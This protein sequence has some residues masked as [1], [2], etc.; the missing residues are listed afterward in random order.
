MLRDLDGQGEVLRVLVWLCDSGSTVS[1]E[2]QCGVCCALF[3]V[4]LVFFIRVPRIRQA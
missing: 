1:S 4:M 2:E 3:W